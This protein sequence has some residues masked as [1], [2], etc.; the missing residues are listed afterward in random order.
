TSYTPNG[1]ILAITS[2]NDKGSGIGVG[3]PSNA[4]PPSA[5]TH[6]PGNER[7]GHFSPDGRWIAYVSHVSGRSTNSYQ[8]YVRPLSSNG[9]IPATIYVESTHPSA[10]PDLKGYEEPYWAPDGQAI[11]YQDGDDILKVILQF[12]GDT[13]TGHAETLFRVQDLW[14]RGIS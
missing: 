4:F 12:S 2:Y 7:F 6:I 11:Y 5:F 13:V 1:S 14:L 9:G 3:S 8:V 10:Q